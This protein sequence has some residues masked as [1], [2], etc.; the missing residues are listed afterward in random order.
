MNVIDVGTPP[1]GSTSEGWT[2]TMVR[3]HGYVNL[4]TTR[5]VRIG[6]H[7]FSCFGH[8]WRI[9]IYPGGVDN[10][11]E[12][13]VAIQLSNKS[14]TS[15]KIQWG[16]SVRDANGKEVEYH[17]PQSF[18]FAANGEDDDNWGSNFAKRSTIMNALVEGSLVIEV[19]MKTTST[20]KPITQF[21]PTN[22]LC[23][24]VLELFMD[25][26]SSDVVFE[27]NSGTSQGE[28][29]NTK[30]SKTTT[31]FHAHHLILKNNT[32]ALHDMC[33]SDES[34]EGITTVSQMLS[35]RFSNTCYITHTEVNFRMRI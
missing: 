19:R 22:P 10:S 8:Q 13:Y 3:F 18:E 29:N 21:I 34:G 5:N 12:G 28:E 25:E 32:S 23:K 15:I 33:K 27:V 9:D 17:K 30:K 14:N 7:E 20:N 11:I 1:D 4:P 26:E 6:S 16:Y 2:T 24:N 31:S 35:P